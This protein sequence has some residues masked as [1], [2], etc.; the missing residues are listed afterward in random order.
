MYGM[1]VRYACTVCMYG[2]HAFL[3]F[4][5]SMYV[6]WL[7]FKD[8]I[9]D[10]SHL[11]SCLPRREIFVFSRSL[12]T[13][14]TAQVSASCNVWECRSWTFEKVGPPS[15]GHSQAGM[16]LAPFHMIHNLSSAQ[17]S[18]SLFI[19]SCSGSG[20]F[21]RKMSLTFCLS[22]ESAWLTV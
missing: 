16:W 2:M 12:A 20:S 22:S 17:V 6:F 7:K 14:G 8:C 19:C 10:K 11:E 4:M 13:S 21:F 1:H 18:V 3:L 15:N 5:P 9:C